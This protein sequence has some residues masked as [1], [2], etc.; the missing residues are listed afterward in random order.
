M[1]RTVIE[2]HRLLLERN[3]LLKE[4]FFAMDPE[5]KKITLDGEK[6]GIKIDI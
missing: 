1:M 6:V 2:E 5:M 4:M 3:L